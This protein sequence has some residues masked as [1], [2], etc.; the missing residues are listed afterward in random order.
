MRAAVCTRYGAPEVLQLREVEKPVPRDDEV[1]IK[2][3]ATAVT[4]SVALC[5]EEP[6]SSYLGT[7]HSVTFRLK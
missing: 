6:I 7:Q 2:V 3:H 1:L 4:S 5:D